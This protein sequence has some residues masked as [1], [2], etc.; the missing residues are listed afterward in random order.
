VQQLRDVPQDASLAID[1]EESGSD[2]KAGELRAI[3][4]T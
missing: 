4:G 1:A 3:V 2:P